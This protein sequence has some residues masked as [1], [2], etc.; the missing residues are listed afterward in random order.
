MP[1][2][3]NQIEKWS[4]S[5]WLLRIYENFLFRLYFR[6]E[7]VGK[8]KL[9]NDKSLIFAPNHQNALIDALAMLTLS[10]SRQ[11][12]F[13]ARADIFGKPFIDKTLT[14]LKILPVYR[15]RDGYENLSLNNSIFKK[16]VDVLHNRNGLVILPEGNH[17]GFKRLRGLKKGIAR[18]ALQTEEA[19]NGT[20]DIHI[21][22][23]GL[24]YSHYVRY[25]SK[26][27]IRIGE[28]FPVKPFL[29]LYKKN[30]A[31][32]Y[33]AIIEELAKR[34]KKEIIHIEEEE[35]YDELCLILDLFSP[36]I[37]KEHKRKTT[38]NAKF[39]VKKEL[40]ASLEAL[41]AENTECYNNIAGKASRLKELLD[42][43][44]VHPRHL[45]LSTG[46]IYLLP[47]HA[48]PTVIL[49]PIALYGIVNH[50]IPILLPYRLS[51]KFK[52]IQFHS[53]V[54]HAASLLL[55]P[56]SYILTGGIFWGISG[57]F[58]TTLLYLASLPI[59]ALIL[60]L[61]KS[62]YRKLRETW[63]A[64]RVIGIKKAKEEVNTAYS[65]LS[66]SIRKHIL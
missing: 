27:L 33:N 17:A 45:P 36:R 9:P 48:L 25:G 49:S 60:F 5:Y 34:I 51:L 18:I 4:A 24:N 23:V 10:K 16:T 6:T 66:E 21:V 59:S 63:R 35:R 15:I 65:D 61:W 31:Q 29:P 57:S 22:P 39:Q 12:I 46:T 28:P 56:L 14:F 55:L 43:Y 3:R 38:Q 58:G 64:F 20:L 62:Q 44:L 8:E 32:A 53:S 26:L 13:L 42:R 2:N 40:I 7:I 1:T 50:V 19:S 30:K 47:L 11:P 54:R 41:K 37:L 52:D